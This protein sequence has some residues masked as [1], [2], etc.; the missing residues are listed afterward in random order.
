MPVRQADRRPGLVGDKWWW[1]VLWMWIESL[2]VHM[3]CIVSGGALADRVGAEAGLD[4]SPPLAC[5]RDGA[6][7]PQILATPHPVGA[8]SAHGRCSDFVVVFPPDFCDGDHEN[9]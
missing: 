3:E 2:V 6:P 9:D 1:L 4:E 5:A 7:K 8:A